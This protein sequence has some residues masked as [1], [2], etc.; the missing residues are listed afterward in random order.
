MTEAKETLVSINGQPLQ[1][2]KVMVL[3]PERLR[4]LV[5]VKRQG[6]MEKW[7]LAHIT[8]IHDHQLFLE[9]E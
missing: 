7:H 2:A 5:Y 3:G 4:Q 1:I 9:L 8:K 6:P